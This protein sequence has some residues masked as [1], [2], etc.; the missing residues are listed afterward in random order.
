MSG[1][2]AFAENLGT[3][4]NIRELKD[5]VSSGA[6]SSSTPQKLV[7]IMQHHYSV[8]KEVIPHDDG[9]ISDYFAGVSTG[10]GGA[11]N[12]GGRQRVSIPTIPSV[13]PAV[14]SSTGGQGSGTAS[15]E[16]LLNTQIGE[17]R[18][19]LAKMDVRKAKKM[20]EQASFY[21]RAVEDKHARDHAEGRHVGVLAAPCI[22]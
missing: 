15:F 14:L 1:S 2:H 13:R 20:L 3:P 18:S 5:A 9:S 8:P 4:K 7:S 12:A 22:C 21:L 16:G 6:D 11:W 17:G 10:A 19:A